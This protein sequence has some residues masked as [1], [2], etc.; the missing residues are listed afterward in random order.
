MRS[1][2]LSERLQTPIS[3]AELE[4]RWGLIRAAMKREGVDVLPPGGVSFHHRLL[5]HG[6]RRNTSAGPRRSLAI[7]LRTEKSN[8]RPGSWVSRYLDQPSISPLIFQR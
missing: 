4:R 1:D 8:P 7:H 3:T 5:I 6:S 2:G